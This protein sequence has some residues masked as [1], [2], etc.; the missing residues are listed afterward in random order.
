MVSK[1]LLLS[2]FGGLLFG[3]AIPPCPLAPLAWIGVAP[4]FLANAYPIRWEQRVLCASIWSSASAIAPIVVSIW[5]AMLQGVEYQTDATFGVVA[6]FLLVA[7]VVGIVAVIAGKM[8]LAGKWSGWQWALAVAFIGVLVEWLSFWLPLPVQIAITQSRWLIFVSLAQLGGIWLVSWFVWFVNAVVAV[9]YLQR[10]V[11]PIAMGIVAVFTLLAF[12]IWRY[13]PQETLWEE[14]KSLTVA[15][16]QDAMGDPLNMVQTVRD[17]QLVVLSELALGQETDLT[18]DWLSATAKKLDAFLVAGFVE[19][20]PPSNAAVLLAP[21]GQEVLRHRKVHLFSDEHRYYQK[22]GEVKAYPPF[23]MAIC[24]D[25]VFPDVVRQL[26]Q[27]GA[28]VIAVPNFDPYVVGYLFHHLHAA[29]LPFRAFENR[30]VIVKADARGLSQA[31]AIDGR[32]VAQAPLGRSTVLY[33]QVYPRQ[34]DSLTP[35]TRW[36]DWFVIL[37]ALGLFYLLVPLF[38]RRRKGANTY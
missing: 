3:T 32:C 6:C 1:A 23:G 16:V 13:T 29:F 35:Y 12:T 2:M 18:Q 11:E 14:S 26:A 28:K 30:V 19:T 17:A 8:W 27:Q 21:N 34:T 10:R 33:A 5:I 37:S 25:T 31:F 24:Y 22:G 36:G 20:Q 9:T 7:L 38:L 15:L 4:L